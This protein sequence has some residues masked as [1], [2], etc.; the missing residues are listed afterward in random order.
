MNRLTTMAAAIGLL[1]AT[2]ATAGGTKTQARAV[3]GFDFGAYKTFSWARGT[4]AAVPEIEDRVIAAIERELGA[5]GLTPAGEG[6]LQ[7]A[8]YAFASLSADVVGR[9]WGGDVWTI[10]RVDANEVA[11]GVLWIKLTPRGAERP[12]WEGLAT[13]TLVEPETNK[14]VAKIDGIVAKIFAER[15]LVATPAD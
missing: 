12:V 1:V 13:K 2:S 5:R 10:F 4:P 15:P 8:S 9:T 6:E 14:V 7:V 3:A 11:N